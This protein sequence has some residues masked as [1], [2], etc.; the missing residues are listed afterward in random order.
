VIWEITRNTSRWGI[1]LRVASIGH[2]ARR[3]VGG[4]EASFALADH[5]I[6]AFRTFP[7]ARLPKDAGAA[8]TPSCPP[9]L[10]QLITTR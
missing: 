5:F 10:L 1:T 2:F 7:V 4:C 6:S 8:G 9:W 3:V